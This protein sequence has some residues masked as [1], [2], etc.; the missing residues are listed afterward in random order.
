MARADAG[1]QGDHPDEY[2]PN[3]QQDKRSS[4]C[5]LRL[6]LN[7]YRYPKI[8]N[9]E[10]HRTDHNDGNADIDIDVRSVGDDAA[11]KQGYG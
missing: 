11:R 6:L 2:M 10:K 3:P 7:L 8:L 1:E 5:G 9:Q 4:L